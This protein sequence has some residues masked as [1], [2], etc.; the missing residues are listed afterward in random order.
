MKLANLSISALTAALLTLPVSAATYIHAGK[1]ITGVDDDVLTEQTI[2]LDGNKIVM[3]DDG[4]LAPGIEDEL[5]DARNKRLCR[6]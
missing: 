1:L 4:Y 6:A 5:I 3:I 2:I